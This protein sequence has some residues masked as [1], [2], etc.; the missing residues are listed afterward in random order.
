[1][2]IRILLLTTIMALFITVFIYN[3]IVQS[4]TTEKSIPSLSDNDI[5]NVPKEEILLDYAMKWLDKYGFATGVNLVNKEKFF[6]ALASGESEL[7]CI[8]EGL[9]HFVIYNG[10]S[11]ETQTSE[12]ENVS[13][14]KGEVSYN[15]LLI[16]F[17][18]NQDGIELSEN[19]FV[20]QGSDEI[21]HYCY[22]NMEKIKNSNA[23][24]KFFKGDRN[25]AGLILK[26]AGLS[27]KCF[28]SIDN[29]ACIVFIEFDD[30]KN[31]R[32]K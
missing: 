14:T 21:I 5:V 11:C 12:T 20:F 16:R 10:V 15:G 4:E 24:R 7:E 3:E 31:P 1:M 17:E 23:K 19:I 30:V 8:L 26:A 9:K 22:N 29:T 28:K 25:K 27:T 13:T 6:I 32:E 2:N 18:T